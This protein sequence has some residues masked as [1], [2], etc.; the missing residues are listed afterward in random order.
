MITAVDVQ[1]VTDE[2]SHMASTFL[3]GGLARAE[4]VDLTGG[5]NDIGKV[6]RSL[7]GGSNRLL[8]NRGSNG[9]PTFIET[10]YNV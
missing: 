8:D 10:R 1:G 4:G 5:M 2:Y 7:E 6:I 3:R 9:L